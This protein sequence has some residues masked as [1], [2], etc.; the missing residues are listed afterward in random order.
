MVGGGRGGEAGED[1]G[2]ASSLWRGKKGGGGWRGMLDAVE[3]GIT[4]GD[5]G[6][7]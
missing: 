2:T 6:C 5:A 7:S 1:A 3:K 4:A